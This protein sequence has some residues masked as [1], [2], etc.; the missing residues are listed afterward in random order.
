MP[1]VASVTVP[2]IVASWALDPEA[3][4][5]LQDV[6]VSIPTELIREESAQVQASR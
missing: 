1:P 3:V 2:A 4:V 6:F 5:A